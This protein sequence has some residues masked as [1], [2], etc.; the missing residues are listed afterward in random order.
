ME[1]DK[2]LDDY[3]MILVTDDYGMILSI[4]GYSEK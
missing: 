3:G 4:T 2:A 1:N